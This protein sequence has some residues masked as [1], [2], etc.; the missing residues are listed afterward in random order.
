VKEVV[1]FGDVVV[2]GNGTPEFREIQP[3][4]REGQVVVDLVRAFGP[5]TSQGAYQGV[6][7]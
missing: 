7:W 6:A 3:A 5:K 2:I 4:L 1:E